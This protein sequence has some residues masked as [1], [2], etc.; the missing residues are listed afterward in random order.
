MKNRIKLFFI[1]SHTGPPVEDFVYPYYRACMS[2]NCFSLIIFFV[3]KHSKRFTSLRKFYVNPLRGPE[4]Q[5]TQMEIDAAS[6]V[7]WIGHCVCL[8]LNNLTKL[9]YILPV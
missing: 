7:L 4:L 8:F 9:F 2:I 1:E 3:I 6:T 5:D